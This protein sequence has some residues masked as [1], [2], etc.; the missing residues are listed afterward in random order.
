MKVN[1]YQLEQI[2]CV[3]LLVEKRT[4]RKYVGATANFRRR[5]LG[6]LNNG[7]I[8]ISF[9]KILQK[10][11][12]EMLPELEARWIEKIKPALN[13]KNDTSGAGH[14]RTKGVKRKPYNALHCLA[15]SKS[16]QRPEVIAAKSNAMIGNDHRVGSKHSIKTRK[17]M[18][19]SG[20]G[21]P[22]SKEHIAA[23]T[24]ALNKPEIRAKMSA[25]K[26]GIPWSVARR[27]TK[28]QGKAI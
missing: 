14:A 2:C 17:K 18:S 27:L 1:P 23:V 15:I 25:S 20:K 10:A 3:Y 6:H 9:F 28:N 24:A 26:T 21:R 8:E 7:R 4:G 19:L 11:K 16:L 12:R 5:I 22:K 13:K